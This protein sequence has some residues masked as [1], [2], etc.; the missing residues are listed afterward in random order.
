MPLLRFMMID[1]TKK[2]NIVKTTLAL[3]IT[4]NMDVDRSLPRDGFIMVGPKEM[5]EDTLEVPGD[6]G[7]K[8]KAVYNLYHN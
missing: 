2:V 5:D 6:E 3:T 8:L 7:L 4:T 1:D